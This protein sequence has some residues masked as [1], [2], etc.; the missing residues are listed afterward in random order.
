MAPEPMTEA[1]PRRWEALPVI[2]VATFMG[3]FD[4][5][6]VNVAAPGMQRDISASSADLQLVI[7]GYAFAYAALLITGG[8]LGDRYSYRLLFLGGMALFTVA[9][10]ACGLAGTPGELIV[11]RVAQGLGAALMVPQVLALITALF[12]PDERHR[13]LAWFGVT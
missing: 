2:L 8:R 1:D 4:I 12:P 9:S 11:A 3:L 7:G 6:V 5:F 13:A 10:A